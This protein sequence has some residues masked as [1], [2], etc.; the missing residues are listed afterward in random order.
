MHGA[1]IDAYIVSTW[2][3]HLN[4]DISDHDKRIQFISGFTG[5]FAYVVITKHSVA[6]WTDEK[7]LAQA[8]SELS[9]DW[10]IFSLNSSPSVIEYL[11]VRIAIRQHPAFHFSLFTFHIV[12]AYS[13]LLNSMSFHS[14]AIVQQIR[15]PYRTKFGWIGRQNYN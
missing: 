4:K 12:N 13:I 15:K 8:N 6:L 1:T 2:D 5:K 7:Y 10:K 11:M 9:C 3:E 14:I